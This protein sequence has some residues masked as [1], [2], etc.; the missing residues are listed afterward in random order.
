[1]Y[2][3][4]MTEIEIIEIKKDCCNDCKCYPNCCSDCKCD[5]A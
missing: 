4:L 5:S 2:N 3:N 1:M